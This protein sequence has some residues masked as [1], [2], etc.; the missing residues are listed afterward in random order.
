MPT[1][2]I[3]RSASAPVDVIR[4]TPLRDRIPQHDQA[5]VWRL[6]D[7]AS[8][9][10]LD[11]I[12]LQ[13]IGAGILPIRTPERRGV[14]AGLLTG[15]DFICH[16]VTDYLDGLLDR[17]RAD[18]IVVETWGEV[19]PTGQPSR[20]APHWWYVLLPVLVRLPLGPEDWPLEEPDTI[21]V[22]LAGEVHPNPAHTFPA[23]RPYPGPPRP[24][25]AGTY[26]RQA[27]T[28]VPPPP[29]PYSV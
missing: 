17:H 2:E 7:R 14:L 11:R 27:A 9:S 8:L 4:I 23:P 18:G 12:A 29:S 28:R 19:Y 26:T 1:E 15:E 16:K 3:V 6:H 21:T 5:T 13:P 20:E 10:L 25:D 22:R 24:L